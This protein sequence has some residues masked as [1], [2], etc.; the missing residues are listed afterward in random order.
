MIR[1]G[2]KRVINSTS[3]TLHVLATIVNSRTRQNLWIGDSHALFISGS[4]RAT[5]AAT[6]NHEDI[7]I[8]L[9]PR[10][11]FSVARDGW[12]L[13]ARVRLIARIRRFNKLIIVMGEIDCRVYLGRPNDT[14]Y[15]QEAWVREFVE[16]AYSLA[17]QLRVKELVFLSPVPPADIGKNDADFP[18]NGSLTARVQGTKWFTDIVTSLSSSRL[19]GDVID[20][21]HLVGNE[22]G[23]L[24]LNFTT[25][26]VHVN[27]KG[28]LLIQ[29]AIRDREVV[30]KTQ[31]PIPSHHQD[32][33]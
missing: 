11:A 15:R 4:R 16:V 6:P 33:A 3:V 10:L 32:G 19:F 23:S 9:G 21:R 8:W 1:S 17:D 27:R 26:G 25:D 20:L 28:S 24:D 29:E 18:R 7:C 12:R 2:I 22:D 14:D 5:V 31:R 13:P 30:A